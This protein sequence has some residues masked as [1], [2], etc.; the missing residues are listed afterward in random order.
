MFKQIIESVLDLVICINMKKK[1]IYANNA[2]DPGMQISG[3]LFGY[4]NQ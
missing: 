2:F 1:I 4:R 3:R